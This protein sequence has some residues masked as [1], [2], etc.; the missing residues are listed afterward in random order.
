MRNVGGGWQLSGLI[1]LQSG[2]FNTITANTATGTRR[3][4]YVGGSTLV[5]SGQRGP[6]AWINTAAFA[7]AGVDHYGTSSAGLVEGPGLQTYDMSLGKY[8]YLTESVNI[9]FQADFFNAF[10]NVNFSG[11]GTVV[12]NGGFRYPYFRVSG[13]Q[14]ATRSEA[15]LL[16]QDNTQRG[17]LR[18][19]L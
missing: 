8:F 4:D 10:N 11:L 18:L 15:I 16:A 12:T 17:G 9:R 2:G 13:A 14:P 1:R 19:A 7:P 5:A 3:A 6:N